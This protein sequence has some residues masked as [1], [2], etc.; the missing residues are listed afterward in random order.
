MLLGFKS[1]ETMLHY[2]GPVGVFR[3][4]DEKEIPDEQAQNL[5]KD[6]PDNFFDA[7]KKEKK[8]KVAG[9]KVPEKNEDK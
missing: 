1:T 9:V 4:G 8:G 6:H 2:T 7:G 3:D 5:I